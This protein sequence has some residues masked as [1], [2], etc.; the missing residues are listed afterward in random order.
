MKIEKQEKQFR[1]ESNGKIFTIPFIS[2]VIFEGKT[3]YCVA[4]ITWDEEPSK[5]ALELIQE[6]SAPKLEK[7]K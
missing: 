3:E 1:V 4:E 2:N 7:K 6:L 5:S